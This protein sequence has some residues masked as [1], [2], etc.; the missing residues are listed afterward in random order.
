MLAAFDYTGLLWAVLI[1][2]IIFG[3][4]PAIN[5][6]FGAAIVVA[7]GLSVV[8]QENRRRQSKGA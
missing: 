4:V 7:A 3:E 2:L 1:G 8:W 6:L 5:V